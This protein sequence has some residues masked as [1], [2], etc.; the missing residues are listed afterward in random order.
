MALRK[1]VCGCRARLIVLPV[2]DHGRID[3]THTTWNPVTNFYQVSPG[4][5]HR[6]VEALSERF[7]GVPGHHHEPCFDMRL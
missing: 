2:A 7:S 5:V 3:W 6:D 4:C 1:L